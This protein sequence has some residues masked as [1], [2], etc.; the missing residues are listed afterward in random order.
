MSSIKNGQISLYCHLNKIIKRPG[1]SFQSPPLRQK[2]VR[3]ICHTVH[4][5]LTKFHFDNTQNSREINIS[6]TSIIYVGMPM[7][8]L[9]ILKSV[10]FTKTRKSRCLKNET[11]FFLQI[12]NSLITHQGLL[13]CKKQFCRRGNSYFWYYIS[14]LYQGI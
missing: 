9:Q 8:M 3:N 7:M 1:T 4:Q 14:L 2:Y 5:Y 11:L 6:V 10:D 13:Y 12:T